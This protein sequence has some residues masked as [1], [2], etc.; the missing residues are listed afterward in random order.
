MTITQFFPVFQRLHRFCALVAV[1]AP[2]AASQAAE[3][4]V[5]TVYTYDS[6]ISEWGP[7]PAVT[8]A[9]EARCGCRL[10]WVAVDSSLGLLGRLQLEGGKSRADVVLGLDA[11][12][13]DEA[14]RTGLFAPHGQDTAGLAL[15]TP[16]TDPLF[17][18]FDYGYFAFIYDSRR[19][20]D[21]P[22]SLHD[23]VFKAPEKL[24]VIIQDPRSSTSGL[25][26]LLWMRRVFGAETPAAW[27]SLA[28]RI[29]TATKSWSEA[30]GM[31]LKG[32]GS[33]VL[34]YTTSPAYHRIAEGVSAYRAAP[35][36]EGHYMQTEVAARLKNAAQPDLADQFMAFLLS[37]EFQQT[38]PTGNWM[39]PVIALK[40]G[41]P[42]G[43]EDGPPPA[44]LTPYDAATIARLRKDWTREWLD[45]TAR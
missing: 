40:D 34:S 33:M 12:L 36:A 37:P 42:A 30:Y 44:A 16:W 3:L 2:L 45:A 28:P 15:P 38:I 22:R 41:L 18:P 21:P 19:L 43:F 17:L 32:E 4:P 25:G 31:F 35:F 5:L 39:Y 26:L 9:F 8:K 27:R 11:A 13:T 24:T 14:A 10:N 23:L 1:I 29:V 6:F 7:G 20:A